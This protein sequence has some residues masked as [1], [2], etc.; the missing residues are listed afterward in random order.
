M[1][2]IPSGPRGLLLSWAVR[3]PHVL[4]V[5][6]PGWFTTRVAAERAVRDRGWVLALG[7]ADADVLLVA[8]VPGP[9]LGRHVDLVHDQLPG[10]R[11]R[12]AA[13]SPDRVD[14]ALDLAVSVLRDDPAQRRDASE[15][16]GYSAPKLDHGEMDH[17]E[18]DHGDMDMSPDGIPLAGGAD[19]R[20]G[21]EMDVLEVRLGPVLRHWPAGLVLTLTLAGDVITTAE[22]ATLTG[23]PPEPE[24]VVG[25]AGAARLLD[26]A[27]DVLTLAGHRAATRVRELRDRSLAGDEPPSRLVAEVRTHADRVRRSRTLR[28]LWRDLDVQPRVQELLE[29]AATLLEGRVTARAARRE[30]AQRAAERLADRLV[31][32]ELAT[33]RLLVSSAGPWTPAPATTEVT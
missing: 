10:P 31:G 11:A 21:L 16:A 33:A 13:Q 32:C 18:M 26:A 23:Q 8:G 22:A 9:E 15:R 28:W 17:G 3:R 2:L 24:A 20:D 29:D 4:V 25:P 14:E 12:V 5:E 7:P 1:G 30:D 6:V 19:D 27:A